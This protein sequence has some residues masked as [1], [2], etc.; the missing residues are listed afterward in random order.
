[1]KER[2]I[3]FSS[4]M[5]KALLAG[6]NT[7]TRR[8]V[9]PQPELFQ[10]YDTTCMRWQDK[11]STPLIIAPDCMKRFSPYGGVG[12]RLWVRETWMVYGEFKNG[13]G[14][15]YRADG[16]RSGKWRPSIFMPRAASRITLEITDVRVER[17]QDISEDDAIAEGI[18]ALY[19][20]EAIA[21]TV[22]L[23]S[24]RNGQPVP[25]TNYL[26]HGRG[27]SE[28]Y[29]SADSARDS[30]RSLWDS[31]NLKRGYGWE[32]NPFVWVV[33]FRAITQEAR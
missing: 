12:D 10:S 2:P 29:S 11:I 31:I 24:Y 1:M 6:K 19:S 9:K 28:G 3:L 18:E 15:A 4:D 33:S 8:V 23:E 14:Y 27:G 30:Y 22:G 7:Q 5:V 25:W 21:T 17:V 32:S 26:W 20:Q 13:T 16:D